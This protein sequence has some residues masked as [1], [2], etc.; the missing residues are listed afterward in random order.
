VRCRPR[1]EVPIPSRYPLGAQIKPDVGQPHA[2]LA[3]SRLK[4]RVPG[5]IQA[6]VATPWRRRLRWAFESGDRI[7]LGEL[8]CRH[9]VARRWRDVMNGGGSGR[10]LRPG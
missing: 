7:G 4:N 5:R 9:L 1:R 10:R 3:A 8:H 6:V 2:S